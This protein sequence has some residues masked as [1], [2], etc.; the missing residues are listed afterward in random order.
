MNCGSSFSKY[1]SKPSLF[2]FPLSLCHFRAYLSTAVVSTSCLG[3]S[4]CSH[5]QSSHGNKTCAVGTTSPLPSNAS[6]ASHFYFLDCF[7]CPAEKT[8]QDSLSQQRD[9]WAP[10]LCKIWLL[11]S[12]SGQL[13]YLQHLRS[14]PFTIHLSLAFLSSTLCK[15]ALL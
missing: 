14:T 3:S 1:S 13:T 8:M 12:F 5:L 11:F 2:Q 9:L 15:S 10:F 6:V 4:P 7:N